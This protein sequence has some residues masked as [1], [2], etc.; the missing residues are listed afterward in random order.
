M[1]SFIITIVEFSLSLEI[2]SLCNLD[3]SPT[4]DPPASYFKQSAGITGYT[5]LPITK[6]SK[7]SEGIKKT[8]WQ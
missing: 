5:T 4:H 6:H 2:V 8:M 1:Y 3:C 7:S